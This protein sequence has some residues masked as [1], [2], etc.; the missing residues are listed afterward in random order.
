MKE[1]N[2]VIHVARMEDDEKCVEN[3]NCKTCRKDTTWKT[4]EQIKG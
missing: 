4:W 2:L 3:F 1:D